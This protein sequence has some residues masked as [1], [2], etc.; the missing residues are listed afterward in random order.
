MCLHRQTPEYLTVN[1]GCGDDACS[2]DIFSPFLGF[3]LSFSPAVFYREHFIAVEVLLK[4]AC[5]FFTA[6]LHL[7]ATSRSDVPVKGLDSCVHFTQSATTVYCI[8]CAGSINIYSAYCTYCES[9][10]SDLLLNLRYSSSRHFGITKKKTEP[11]YDIDETL[12][13]VLPADKDPPPG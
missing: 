9:F 7:A 4:G 12:F 13:S 8:I 11:C 10:A 2:L 3:N 5:V 1:T 6:R